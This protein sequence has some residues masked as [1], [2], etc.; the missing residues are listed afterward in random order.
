MIVLPEVLLTT[1]RDP[2]GEKSMFDGCAM[3][4]TENMGLPEG[5]VMRVMS[6]SPKYATRSSAEENRISWAVFSSINN[7]SYLVIYV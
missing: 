5:R 7:E 6:R 1:R 4:R 2:S 3:G